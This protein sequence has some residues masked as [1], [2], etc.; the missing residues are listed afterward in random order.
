MLYCVYM[1]SVA[2]ATRNKMGER[3]FSYLLAAFLLFIPLVAF[4][5]DAPAGPAPGELAPEGGQ[6]TAQDLGLYY[7]EATGLGTEDIRVII[8]RVIRIGLGLLGIIAVVIVIAGGVIWMT[9]GGDDKKVLLAKKVMTNGAIGLAIILSSFTITHFVLKSLTDATTGAGGFGGEGAGAGG[10]AARL[11]AYA[12]SRHL[13]TVIQDHYP[14]RGARNIPRNTQIIITFREPMQLESL[15]KDTNGNGTFGDC[16]N[17]QCDSI[18]AENVK[19]AKSQELAQNIVLDAVDAVAAGEGRTITYIP[20]DYLGAANESV[21][22]TV[23]LAKIKRA[24]GTEAFGGLN[25]TYEW[26]FTTNGQVDDTPPSV[27]RVSPTGEAGPDKIVQLTF[28]EP[29]S[30]VGLD[31]DTD[32]SHFIRIYVPKADGALTEVKGRFRALNEYRSATFIPEEACGQNACGEEKR[33]LPRDAAVRVLLEAATLLRPDKPTGLPGSGLMDTSGNSLDGGGENG[34][35]KDGT[36]S[37]PPAVAAGKFAP[38]NYFWNF[39]TT[40]RVDVSSPKI[41]S[42]NPVATPVT[43]GVDPNMQVESQFDEEMNYATLV[44]NVKF[45]AQADAP[46]VGFATRM[47]EE[48]LANGA[49]GTKL[50][51]TPAMPFTE[52]TYYAPRL[53][54]TIQDASQNCYYPAIGPGCEALGNDNPSCCSLRRDVQG[55]RPA[56]PEGC[57]EALVE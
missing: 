20:R 25:A 28:S 29:M 51:I 16:V 24:N 3:V 56:G 48:E 52:D 1:H 47:S 5:Q 55:A 35:E 17:G 32:A 36:A 41:M 50:L 6:V 8:A 42:V 33:C 53:P 26:S 12:G 40:N 34:V 49:I 30:P 23:R 13:G 46:P 37:G 19:I 54:H 4:A 7:G 21:A 45:D 15:L 39:R 27:L 22:Y 11:R 9:A 2:S 31:V 43:G 10:D 44:D 18:N 38:D 14:G 57:A